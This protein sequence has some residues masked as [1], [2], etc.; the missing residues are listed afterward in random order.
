[1]ERC[2]YSEI[3]YDCFWEISDKD[4][5]NM[6]LLTDDVLDG[7]SALIHCRSLNATTLRELSGPNMSRPQTRPGRNT[8][9]GA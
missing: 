4:S 6:Q 2:R 8:C 9:P 7:L 3:E 5:K 1:E